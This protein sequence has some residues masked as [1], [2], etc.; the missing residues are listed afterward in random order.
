MGRIREPFAT[1]LAGL[2]LAALA[3]PPAAPAQDTT[4]NP[5]P[6]TADWAALAELPDWSGIWTPDVTDQF[7]QVTSNQPPWR[8]DVAVQV[9]RLLAEDA[10]GRPQGLFVNCLPEGMPSWML[11]SHNAMEI[12]FTPGRVTMLGESDNNR[13]RRIYTD[14]RDHPEDPDPTFHG[15]SVGRWDGDTLI[16][17]TIGVLPQALIAIGESVGVPNNGDMHIVERIHLAGPDELH[18]KLTITAPRVLTG[19]WRTT[20]IY[21]RQRARAYDIVEGICIHGSFLEET[22]ENGNEIFVPDPQT[23]AG[24]PIPAGR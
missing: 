20:R 17:D 6:S 22:D 4:V 19:P 9:D 5:P 24:I 7:D 11:I 16:V 1:A 21:Y 3:T 2:I 23:P 15:H 13:L 10:A 14:G 8:P 12:L 18:D